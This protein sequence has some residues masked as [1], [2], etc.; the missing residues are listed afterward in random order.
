[1][2]RNSQDLTPFH[3]L[4][5]Q[6][7]TIHLG[8]IWMEHTK[9]KSSRSTH[10]SFVVGRLEDDQASAFEPSF[11]RSLAVGALTYQFTVIDLPD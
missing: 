8:R 4:P 3:Q 9:S 10:S 11:A 6:A 1:M 2:V 7:R 5:R